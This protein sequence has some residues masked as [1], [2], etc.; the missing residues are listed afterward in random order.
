VAELARGPRRVR[1]LLGLPA[2]AGSRDN[3]AE[4]IGLLVGTEQAI[5]VAGQPS[6]ADTAE[7][8]NA[9]ALRAL[10]R[11]ANLGATFAMAT[12]GIGS[13]LPGTVLDS[14][15]CAALK[16]GPVEARRLAATLAQGK[17]EDEA[18]RLSQF[19]ERRIAER[20][21]AWRILGLI[22]A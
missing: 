13:P 7:R 4:L 1:D 14:Y 15:L 12:G 2:V 5:P 10:T 3:P 20:A 8:F 19:I 11:P 22:P 17:P 16:S 18:E 21:P 6:R 9:A